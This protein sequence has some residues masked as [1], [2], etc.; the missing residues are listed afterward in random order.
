VKKEVIGDCTLYHGDSLDVLQGIEGVHACVTDP[1]YHLTSIVK[2]Y[3]SPN[4][5]PTTKGVYGRSTSGFMGQQWDGGDI[6]FRQETWEKVWNTLLPGAHLLAFS[7]T[8]TYHRMACAIED[9][10]FEIRDMIEWVYGSG[11]PKSHDIS[12][13]GAE[14]WEG[15]GTALKPSQEPIA[16]ARKPLSEKTVAAN[17]LKHGT[18]ALNID[19]CRIGA[20]G[21]PLR[22][23]DPK[24]TNNNTYQGRMDNSLAGGSKAVGTTDQGR[25]AAN[26][27][28]DGSD[29]VKELFPDRKTTWVASSH[30]NNRSGEFLGDLKHPG[31]QGFNDSGSAARFFYC[32]KTAKSERGDFNDHPTVKPI[33]LMS[34]LARLITPPKGIVL[35]PFMGS[36]STALACIQE[37]FNFIGIEREDKYFDIACKRIEKAWKE[38]PISL[39]EHFAE[40]TMS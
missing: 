9:A 38:K 40:A 18:G 28:H 16:V 7:G 32:A 26:F 39:E 11:F 37:G 23:V 5:A 2:R 6:S 14:E 3:G 24:D 25:W 20:N 17:V 1:P 34:Y 19:G 36:G 4:S 33:A 22:V 35:D 10:G 15:W 30:Q 31:N 21:R 13:K 29:E 27:I 12:K 8:R